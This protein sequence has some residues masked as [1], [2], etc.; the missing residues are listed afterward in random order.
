MNFDEIASEENLLDYWKLVFNLWKK[1]PD[2]YSKLLSYAG[3]LFNTNFEEYAPIHMVG[4]YKNTGNKILLLSLHPSANMKPEYIKFEHNQRKFSAIRTERKEVEWK[5]QIRFA[6]NYFTILREHNI[7]KLNYTNME[8]LI[9]YYEQTTEVPK[10]K[11]DLL[12]QKLINV[13]ILPFYSNKI[14]IEEM[15][16]VIEGSLKRIKKFYLENEFDNLLI[17]GKMLYEGLLKLGFV[18]TNEEEAI[19]ITAQGKESKIEHFKL[20]CNSLQKKGIAIPYINNV[21]DEQKKK[22]AREMRKATEWNRKNNLEVA[23]EQ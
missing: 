4:D 18:R 10:A 20:E 17:N 14:A 22:V 6:T 8:K 3:E 7:S 16:P 13:D 15:N 2:L 12:Q 11:Y 1:T 19:P 9:R 23:Q 21:S 5:S